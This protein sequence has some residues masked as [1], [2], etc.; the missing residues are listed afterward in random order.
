ADTN[1]RRETTS[2][3]SGDYYLANLPPSP[4]RIEVEKAGFKKMVQPDVILHVLDA[5]QLDFQLAQRPQITLLSAC[6]AADWAA[7]STQPS[8][9][10]ANKCTLP[11]DT[12]PNRRAPL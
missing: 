9:R 4:Y 10:P 8:R 5:L 3:A 6:G 12:A 11:P 2:D 7:H 1:V